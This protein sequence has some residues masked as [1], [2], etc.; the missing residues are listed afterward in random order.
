MES[1]FSDKL[2]Q[3]V[4]VVLAAALILSIIR[5]N[6]LSEQIT[7]LQKQQKSTGELLQLGMQDIYN[8]IDDI[9]KEQS[10]II[11]SYDCK[12]GDIKEGERTVPVKIAV[13]PKKYTEDT[14][15]EIKL[16]SVSLKTVKN[17][18][19]EF[20]AEYEADIF[21]SVQ[22]ANVYVTNNGET[23]VQTVNFEITDIYE[24]I[25]PS[26]EVNFS[27]SSTYASFGGKLTVN[28]TAEVLSQNTSYGKLGDNCKMIISVNGEEKSSKTYESKD[29]KLTAEINESYVIGKNDVLQIWFEAEDSLGYIHRV[30]AYGYIHSDDDS[31]LT[32]TKTQYIFD[33]DG[34]QLVPRNGQ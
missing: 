29:G 28:G 18:N 8:K 7:E 2:W 25:L 4:S 5:V 24:K 19:G 3:I 13:T 21:D 32:M 22:S 12:I 31:V 23:S 10:N 30:F 27:G 26:F 14:I 9:I 16:G 33:A 11:L 1:K 20:C 17:A 34:N 6:D 15:V